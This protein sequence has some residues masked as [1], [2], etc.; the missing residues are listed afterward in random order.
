MDSTIRPADSGDIETIT[1]IYRREVLDGTGTFEL[2]PP[3]AAE[4]GARHAR[5]IAAGYPFLVAETAGGVCG[6]AYAGAF[7]ERPAF[8]FL[9]ED[10]VYVAETARGSGIGSALVTA[11]VEDCA[12]RG[13][14]QMIAVIGDSANRGSIRIHER[15]GFAPAGQ[16]TS[17]G[18]KAGRWLDIVLMQR[19]LGP[20]D[21][22]SV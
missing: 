3:D 6:Y 2:V 12:T 17:V 19:A 14:R 8:R 5:I 10:S 11:L 9:V 4:M 16:M 20:G 18:W 22:R 1:A 15:C 13:F 21:T 7:R